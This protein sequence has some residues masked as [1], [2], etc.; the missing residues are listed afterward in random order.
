MNPADYFTLRSAIQD[1]EAFRAV[2]YDDA[3]GLPLLRGDTLRG[4]LTIGWGTNISTEGIPKTIAGDLL[5]QRLQARIAELTQAFPVVLTLDATRQIVLGNMA[6]NLG[7]P[8]LRG[9]VKM[10][11]AIQRGDFAG[12]AAEMRASVWAQQV[13]ARAARLANE[14]ESGLTER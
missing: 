12:A 8:R 14:M 4:N 13:G 2:P 6:Y 3:T 1:D 10:W 11:G 9:F 5:D 7:V